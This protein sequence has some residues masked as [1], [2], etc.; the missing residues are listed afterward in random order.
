MREDVQ[1][2]PN[3]LLP[4]D[5][6]KFELVSSIQRVVSAEEWYLKSAADEYIIVVSSIMLQ[7]VVGL[8]VRV[9]RVDCDFD[10]S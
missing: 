8:L 7:E 4:S 10:C 2:E 9:F 3:E 1:L 5:V 6:F